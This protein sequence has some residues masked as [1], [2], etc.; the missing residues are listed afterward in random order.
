MI[1][2]QNPMISK[3]E[4]NTV[5][6][7]FISMLLIMI[8]VGHHLIDLSLVGERYFKVIALIQ[9]HVSTFDALLEREQL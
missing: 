6:L 1:L 7:D 5:D 2:K 8:F 4:D 3:R 9:C